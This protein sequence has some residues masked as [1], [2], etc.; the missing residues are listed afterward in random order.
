MICLLTLSL[1]SPS[2]MADF[3]IVQLDGL[4]TVFSFSKR[5]Y[6]SYHKH[7]TDHVSKFKFS[8]IRCP[9]A[10]PMEVVGRSY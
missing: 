9:Y 10:I 1:S 5:S 7:D 8:K 6:S 3:L 4:N 2:G